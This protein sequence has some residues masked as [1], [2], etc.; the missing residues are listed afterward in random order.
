MHG[1]PEEIG[2][3]R[4][5]ISTS[6]I[7]FPFKLVRNKIKTS[8]LCIFK[9]DKAC[10]RNIIFIVLLCQ[11]NDQFRFVDHLLVGVRPIDDTRQEDVCFDASIALQIKF[12]STQGCISVEHLLNEILAAQQV[13]V[14]I[15]SDS[16]VV[17]IDEVAEPER[18]RGVVFLIYGQVGAVVEQVEVKNCTLSGRHKVVSPKVNPLVLIK[19]GFAGGGM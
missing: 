5:I 12:I 17:E 9:E 13:F 3:T 6:E 15:P 4:F 7:I 8:I 19:V 11:V 14:F 10:G 16:G 1:D 18:I 2:V